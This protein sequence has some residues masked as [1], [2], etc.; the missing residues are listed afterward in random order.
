MADDNGKNGEPI[1]RLER[2]G[3]TFYRGKERLDV[4]KDL[5]LTVPT[6]SFEALM[7]PSGSGKSTLLN[8]IAGL[9]EPSAGRLTVAGSDLG[10]MGEGER[11]AWRARNI[12]FVFQTYNL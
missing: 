3:K 8:L 4:L 12:G 5:D 6:G 11:A 10:Q 2:V 1:I 7:G 9:D